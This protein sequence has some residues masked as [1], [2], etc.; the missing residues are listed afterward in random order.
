MA[1]AAS[2]FLDKLSPTQ[3]AAV[4][5]A[6]ERRHYHAGEI[7]CR[8]GA[9]GRACLILISGGAMVQGIRDKG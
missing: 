5:Q 9:E 8:K 6:A 7:L 3:R 2:P 4:E 1:P